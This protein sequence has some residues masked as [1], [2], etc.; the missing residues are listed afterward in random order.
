M[1]R[2]H[3]KRKAR[4]HAMRES[5]NYAILRFLGHPGD[6]LGLLELR[7]AE[8]KLGLNKPSPGTPFSN[9]KGRALRVIARLQD[10]R[11]LGRDELPA[12]TQETV[13]RLRGHLEPVRQRSPIQ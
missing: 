9:E 11:M 2:A 8:R 5:V 7:A 10:L 3:F 13:E 6:T 1:K 4:R 12:A